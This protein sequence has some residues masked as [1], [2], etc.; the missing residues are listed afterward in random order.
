M[1]R[2]IIGP[3]ETVRIALGLKGALNAGGLSDEYLV[4]IATDRDLAETVAKTAR[5]VIREV[6]GPRE[7][8]APQA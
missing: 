1:K 3:E 5:D 8:F 6:P 2:H 4:R 7:H